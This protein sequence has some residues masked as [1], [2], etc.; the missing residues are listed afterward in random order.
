MYS[1]IPIHWNIKSAPAGPG[2]SRVGPAST[3]L[4][5]W[6]GTVLI[7]GEGEN[8]VWALNH[9]FLQHNRDF[10]TNDILP[11]SLATAWFSSEPKF[12]NKKVSFWK[13]IV[14]SKVKEY[15]RAQTGESFGCLLA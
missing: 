5:S 11:S 9:P 2:R 7:V 1:T 6:G 14:F 10:Q 12:L 13:R 3:Y 15:N 4:A 8:M